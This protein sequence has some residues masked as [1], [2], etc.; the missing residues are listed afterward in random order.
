M[1]KLSKIWILF[2]MAIAIF[3]MAQETDPKKLI[4]AIIESHLENLDEETNVSLV[5]EDL[6]DLAENPIN[7]NA[8]NQNELSRLYIL[9]DIQIEKLLNYVNE[10]GPVYSIFEL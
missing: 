1:K 5:I 9:N 7:I 8:T 3:S 10:Y 4:E 6:E 2:F